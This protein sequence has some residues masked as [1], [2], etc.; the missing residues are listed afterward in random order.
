MLQR[1]PIPPELVPRT[2][3]CS[4]EM[5]WR[6]VKMGEFTLQSQ[7]SP[8]VCKND[9]IS[10]FYW[11]KEEEAT[12]RSLSLG[13]AIWETRPFLVQKSSVLNHVFPS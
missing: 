4:W 2:P 3:L 12:A 5:S 9:S 6:R 11:Q 1:K 13:K 10:A 8:Q 7:K